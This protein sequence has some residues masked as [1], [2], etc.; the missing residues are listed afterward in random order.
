[1]L[2]LGLLVLVM[3]IAGCL[4]GAKS[5]GTG[6]TVEKKGNVTTYRSADDV[7]MFTTPP[8]PEQ[9]TKF[10]SSQD[11]LAKNLNNLFSQGKYNITAYVAAYAPVEHDEFV[12]GWISE[13][14]GDLPAPFYYAMAAKYDA[15]DTRMALRWYMRGYVLAMV[16]GKMCRDKSA[17]QGVQ[18]LTSM[19]GENLRNDYKQY[20]ESG[21]LHE[22]RLAALHFVR[23]NRQDYTP[24]WLCSHGI[25]TFT[26]GGNAGHLPLEQRADKVEELTKSL[27]GK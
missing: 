11:L 24:M 2:R 10:A 9:A 7:T 25:T 6:Y 16:D 26:E 22:E 18:Y 20:D 15:T 3:M 27:P 19:L 1:M 23:E 21:L 12:R 5:S 17:R 4:G 14:L 8:T 13:R